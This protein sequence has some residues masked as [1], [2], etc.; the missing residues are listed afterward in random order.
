MGVVVCCRRRRPRFTVIGY[1]KE[2]FLSLIVKDRIPHI[3]FHVDPIFKEELEKLPWSIPVADWHRYGVTMLNIK[4]GMSRHEVVFVR[5]GRFSFCV[6]EISEEISKKEINHYEHL[7]MLGIHTLVPAGYIIREEEP[8]A[9]ATPVG[10]QYQVNN[11]SHTITVLVNKVLPDSL[12]YSRN[13]RA[14]TR[15]KIWDAIIRL[16]VQLHSNGVYWGDASL[17]NTLIKFE[18][19]MVPFVGPQTVLMAY[20]SDAETVEIRPKLSKSMR[21]ED[22]NF[23]F[24]SMDWVNEDLRK[25]GVV[26]DDAGMDEDKGYIK[27]RYAMLYG[28]EMK[29][30]KFERLT[31]FNVDRFLGG[32]FNPAYVDQF[33]RHIEEHR[34]YL[35][36]RMKRDVSLAEATRDWYETIFVPI[37]ELFRT[38]RILDLFKGKTAAEMYIEIMNN[39]YYLSERAGRDVGMIA[40]MNDYALK[41]GAAEQNKSLFAHLADGMMKILG[42]KE[43]VLLR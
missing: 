14:E 40:A 2:I 28:V 29:K 41:F 34:W 1:C 43:S 23:F 6:K 3:R 25:D 13:F 42:L 10:I 27:E 39:K 18:K 31:S 4:R 19:Q 22:L 26:R 9:V 16:F 8:L 35:G 33:L 30:K 17:A 38:E 37:C 21:E 15:R 24:E 12:L 5:T 11:I 36:E 32:I 20:L 7:L